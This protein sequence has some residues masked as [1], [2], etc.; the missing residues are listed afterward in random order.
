VCRSNSSDSTGSNGRSP[1]RTPVG[2]LALVAEGVA[3]SAGFAFRAGWWGGAAAGVEH[4]VDELEDGALVG[5]RELLDALETLQQPRSL[6]R[7]DLAEGFDGEE[8]IGGAAE[9]VRELDEHRAGRLR[10]VALV[11]GDHAIGDADR[12]AQL[13]LGEAARLAE[14]SQARRSLRGCVP[15]QSAISTCM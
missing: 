15:S 5:G 6:G 4:G 14:R 7:E 13:F 2:L 8:R 11:V 3:H 9:G 12:G 10:T 1:T